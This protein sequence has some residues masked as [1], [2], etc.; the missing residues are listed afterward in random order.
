M[1]IKVL[2]DTLQS[3]NDNMSGSVSRMPLLV[4]YTHIHTHTQL[5]MHRISLQKYIKT[6][7]SFCP[8][9]GDWGLGAE[10][11]FLFPLNTLEYFEIYG[12]PALLN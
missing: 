5:Y 6:E 7:F 1:I 11:R 4:L 12:V 10:E 9:K 3:E 8:R 2:Q